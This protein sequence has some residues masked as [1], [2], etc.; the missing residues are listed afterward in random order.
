MNSIMIYTG[1]EL[2]SST[3]PFSFIIPIPQHG[4]ELTRTLTG[5]T[6]W[7]KQLFMLMK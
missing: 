3:F 2:L 1:S 6:C 4:I 7:V 5:V